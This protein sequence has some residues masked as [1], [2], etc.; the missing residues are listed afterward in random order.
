LLILQVPPQLRE[1]PLP[2]E[3]DGSG[4]LE[5]EEHLSDEDL[6]FVQQ[7]KQQL[8]FLANLDKEALDR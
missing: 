7:H 6:E 2:D 1:L 8:G 3:V 4:G 5:S